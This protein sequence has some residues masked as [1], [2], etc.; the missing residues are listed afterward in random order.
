ML[1]WMCL[2]DLFVTG[3]CLQQCCQTWGIS[4]RSAGNRSSLGEWGNFKEIGDNLGVLNMF[5]TCCASF[6]MADVALMR[7]DAC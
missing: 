6:Y 3:C 4:P 5:R 1:T 7:F 2:F